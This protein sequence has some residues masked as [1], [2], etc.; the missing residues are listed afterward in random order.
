MKKAV[1]VAWMAARESGK[2]QKEDIGECSAKYYGLTAAYEKKK[3]RNKTIMSR[4]HRLAE[5]KS[6]RHEN[7]KWRLN[8]CNICLV[9]QVVDIKR[10]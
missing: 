9:A 6:Q 4:R 2:K 3:G 7:R 1:A 8:L 10:S 5:R